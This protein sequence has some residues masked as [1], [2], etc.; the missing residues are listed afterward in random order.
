MPINIKSEMTYCY[1]KY[2]EVIS[3]GRSTLCVVFIISNASSAQRYHYDLYPRHFEAAAPKKDGK[4]RRLLY[5]DFKREIASVA[6]NS[7]YNE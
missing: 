7:Q 5:L 4:R 3:V 1:G 2:I 6:E